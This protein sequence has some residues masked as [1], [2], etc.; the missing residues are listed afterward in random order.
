[1]YVCMSTPRLATEIF[2][3]KIKTLILTTYSQEKYRKAHSMKYSQENF[4]THSQ[5]NVFFKRYNYNL[6]P[7]KFLADLMH[8]I[9]IL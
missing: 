4:L 1:M 6:L 2:S 5:E 9:M 8:G 3:R 7:T